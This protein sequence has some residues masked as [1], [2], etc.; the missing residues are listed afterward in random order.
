MRVAVL[1]A[2]G[3]VG[4]EVCLLLSRQPGVEVVPVCRNRMGSAFLRSRGIACRHGQPT[5]P[6]E[7]GRLYG[8]CDAVAVFSLASLVPDYHAAKKIHDRLIENAVRRS[9]ATARLIY[10]STQS[11]YGDAHAGQAVV[12]R[13]LYGVEK[14]R[15]ERVLRR[16]AGASAKAAWVFRL[17]HVCGELQ[18]IT[19][20]IRRR[21]AAG[22]VPVPDLTRASNTVHVATI[23]EAIL[24]AASG[25]APS[26]TFDLMNVP[27]WSWQ[28]V[29][30][31]EARSVGVPAAFVTYAEPPATRGGGGL[32]RLPGRVL[33]RLATS[34]ESRKLGSRLWPLL[35]SD[36]AF[37]LKAAY[38]V[39]AAA[40]EIAKLRTPPEEP[41]DATL[42]RPVGTA[43]LPGLTRTRDLLVNP[44]FHL[45]ERGAR[46][47]WPD[48]LPFAPM[49]GVVAPG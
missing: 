20:E 29:F 18:G 21:I 42:F 36:R 1:G 33:L 22:P 37:R 19:L 17:G 49:D 35:P 23:A 6:V 8:D 44:A 47:A 9:A 32:A 7:A 4:A 46:P 3:Q 13:D 30:E 16:L 11:V 40:R 48:D 24:N 12:V 43:F 10:F 41:L 26:G 15:C 34:R 28:E 31:S 5:D 25:A 39:Q 27:Q 38:A 45:P 2:N 14:L